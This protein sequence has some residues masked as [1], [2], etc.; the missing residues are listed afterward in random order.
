MLSVD[1][2]PVGE[3]SLTSQVTSLSWLLPLQNSVAMLLSVKG[4]HACSL[5]CEPQN[6]YPLS[7]HIHTMLSS[8]WYP[9]LSGLRSSAHVVFSG[10]PISTWIQTFDMHYS[11]LNQQINKS[12]SALSLSFSSLQWLVVHNYKLI[13]HPTSTVVKSLFM[14]SKFLKEETTGYSS[15]HTPE[16]LSQ[17]QEP[18]CSL[19]IHHRSHH[20]GTGITPSKFVSSHLDS[21]NMFSLFTVWRKQTHPMRTSMRGF[22]DEKWTQAS[23]QPFF[24]FFFF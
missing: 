1:R 9:A 12:I 4:S 18:G 22:S 24:F 19:N 15:A 16:Y 23:Y 11:T 20:D 5:K 10:F 13:A 14:Y 21:N 2:E 7:V 17:S 8:S 3:N 6:L